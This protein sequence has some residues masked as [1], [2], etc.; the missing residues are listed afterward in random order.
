M[1]SQ[2]KLG[3]AIAFSKAFILPSASYL[4]TSRVITQLAAKKARA[5]KKPNIITNL[6]AGILMPKMS[7]TASYKVGY[8]LLS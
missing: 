1:Y 7:S 3:L 4:L 5:T 2:A 8:I 6:N